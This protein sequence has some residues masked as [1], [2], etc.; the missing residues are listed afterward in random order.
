[1]GLALWGWWV[2][3]MGLALWVPVP[4]DRLRATPRQARQPRGLRVGVGWWSLY[5]DK[6]GNRAAYGCFKS[7]LYGVG[8]MGLVVP[9]RGL[10]VALWG[11]LY[12][13]GGP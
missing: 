10:R 4:F 6:L 2:G 5:L 1:M 8:F 9:E 11:W 12:G 13:V 7:W 3:F